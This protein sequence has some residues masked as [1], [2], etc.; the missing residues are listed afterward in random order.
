MANNYGPYYDN[1]NTEWFREA[2]FGMFIHWGVYALPARGEWVRNAEK[3]TIEDY[4]KYLDRFNPHKYDPRKWAKLAKKAGMKYA[5]MT[6]KHHDGFCMFDS[7]LT[8]YKATNTLAGRDLIREY[9]DAFRAEGIKVGFYY[10]V[11][12][13][14][15]PDYPAYGDPIHPMSRNEAFKNREEHFENYIKYLHGQV[16][17]LA[18]NYGKIDIFWFDYSYGEMSGEKWKAYELVQMVRE[19]QPQA[20]IDN[21]LLVDAKGRILSERE[22]FFGGDFVSPEQ[23]IPRQGIRDENGEKLTWEAC[24]TLNNNWG[25]A[26]QDR[27]YKTVTDVIH[28]LVECVSKDGNLLLN[29]GPNAYGEIPDESIRI[30]EEVGLWMEKNS[31]SIYGCVAADLSK[32]EWGRYTRKGNLLYAHL[33]ERGIGPTEFPELSHRVEYISFLRDGAEIPFK[34]GWP[35]ESGN[36]AISFVYSTLADPHDTVLVLELDE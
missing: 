36:V 10:S 15:H 35:V 3:I 20:I 29:V 2:R 11:I 30:L 22:L 28:M 13:W 21:R 23:I 1:K 25:Y 17:E 33:F 12:D 16:R 7:A 8:D 24:I 26:S 4:Q 32:P 34:K 31:E 9:V 14:H 19:L 6:A 5:V 18:T 27:N